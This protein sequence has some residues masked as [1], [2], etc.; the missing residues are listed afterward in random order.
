MRKFLKSNYPI[1]LVILLAVFF[2]FWQIWDLPGGLFPDEAANGLDV[3]SILQG[4]LKPFYERGNG[5]EALFFYALAASVALFGRG[6]WQHHAVSATFGVLAVLATYFLTKRFFA[7]NVALLAAFFM[8]VSS[9]AVTLSRTAFRANALPLFT[10][11]TLFFLVKF[12][13]SKSQKTKF[14]SAILTGAFFGLGFY[15]YISYRM[16]IVFFVGLIVVVAV[17]NRGKLSELIAANKKYLAGAAAGF[18]A[19]FSWIG[20]YFVRNPEAFF[21]RVGHV[22]IFSKDLNQGDILGTFLAVFKKTMLAFFTEGDLNFRHNVAGYPFLP[23]ILSPFFAAS[24]LIF[25]VAFFV[26]IKQAWDKRINIKV[27]YMGITAAWFWLMLVPEVTTAEGIPHGLRL[28]GVI[29][30]IFI[31]P[32]WALAELWERLRAKTKIGIWS[33]KAYAVIIL[34]AVFVYNFYLYFGVAANSKEYYYAFRSDLTVVSEHIK[35]CDTKGN[36]Y[37]SLD[38]FSVQTVEYLT[39]GSTKKYYLLDPAKT[40]EVT[41][42]SGDQ[43]IFTQS[44]LYDRILF[45]KYHPGA[46]L[47][48]EQKNKFGEPIML[49][50]EQL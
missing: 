3:N 45:L 39:T 38:K 17:A 24:L 9:Y 11:L 26:L 25:T 40:Y 37:L 4:D 36:L 41:L 48:L 31:M 20:Y 8:A 32:A 10:I 46:K 19:A 33:K 18:A 27:F 49:V 6:A 21:T 15:T 2:R 23:Q 35:T 50:Y 44:T 16:M 47:I 28:V 43:V 1:I 7:K 13:Q 34:S 12:I 42:K 29:P 22:S 30:A 14:Y 5:R